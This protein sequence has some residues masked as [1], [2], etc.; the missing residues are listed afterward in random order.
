MI[1][2]RARAAA[3]LAAGSIFLLAGDVTGQA[4]TK[5]KVGHFMSI[6]TGGLYIAAEWGYFAEQGVKLELTRFKSLNNATPA[7]ATGRLDAYAG[8]IGASLFNAIA[9]GIPIK[10]VADKGQE[11]KGSG[12]KALVARKDLY[13]SGSLRTLAQIK[14]K[15]IAILPRGSSMDFQLHLM[16]SAVG[17]SI[18]DVKLAFMGAAN[19]AAALKSKA[20]DAAWSFEPLT[21]RIE[22][23]GL[24][25]TIATLDQFAPHYQMGALQYSERFAGQRRKVAERFMV[26]YLKGV[27]AYVDAWKRRKPRG[28][29]VQVLIKYTPL[30]NRAAYEKV[31]WA[32]L[33]P[34]GYLAVE[35]IQKEQEWYL[36]QGL[37]TSKVPLDKVVDHSFVEYAIKVL[38]RY[39]FQR[40]RR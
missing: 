24:G 23:L 35:S 28:P 32:P 17:L 26:A 3:L 31:R 6:S 15:R 29:V 39:R 4:S 9:R 8:G 2:V 40:E 27:R 37:I 13:D 11:E 12:Y 34:D 21:T 14:G 36:E 25:V 18:S 19:N 30:K 22:G 20:V 33:N 16:L 10:V 1:T 38:G 5:V 7:L